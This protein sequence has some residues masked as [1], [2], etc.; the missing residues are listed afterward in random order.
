MYLAPWQDR[1]PRTA[2]TVAPRQLIEA[3]AY[4]REV[5]ANLN[6]L[7]DRPTLIVGGRLIFAFGDRERSR[8]EQIF[9]QH[10]TLLF[11]KA[12]HFLQEDE[13]ERIA[14]AIRNFCN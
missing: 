11:D 3:S 12:S 2:A 1:A 7:A 5:E 14:E 13:G 8:F 10:Q 9:R 4:L 6:K